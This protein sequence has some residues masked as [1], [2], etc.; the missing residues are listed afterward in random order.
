MMKI[1]MIYKLYRNFP[2][3]EDLLL[4][5]SDLIRGK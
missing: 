2:Q 1:E 3:H 5:I 4:L